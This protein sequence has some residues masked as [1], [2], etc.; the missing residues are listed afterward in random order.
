V[1]KYRHSKKTVIFIVIFN[2]LISFGGGY[3]IRFYITFYRPNIQ[4]SENPFII[5]VPQGANFDTILDSLD[6]QQ[7]LRNRKSFIRAAKEEG[8]P[9][10]IKGGRYE[11]STGMNNKKVVRRLVLGQQKPVNLVVSGNIRS[12]ERLSAVLTRNIEADSL[13]MLLLLTDEEHINRMGFDSTSLFSLIL[14]NT[15]EVY[16]NASPQNII[17]RLY[18]EYNRFWS[19]ERRAKASS[20][21]LSLDQVSTLASIVYEETRYQ[22][23]MATIAGVYMNRLKRGI[24]LQADPTLIFSLRDPTIRRVLSVDTKVDSPYN[25]YKHQGLPPGPICVPSLATIDAVLNYQTHNYLFFC[26]NSEFTGSHL[27]ATNYSDHLRNAKAYHKA[28]NERGI[29]R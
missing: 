12:I 23:E 11:L 7:C 9:E 14:P 16:W 22:P 13:S 5:Y 6:A 17:E 20:I 10:R 25:T 8:L 18:K 19:E 29:K 24:P 2:L 26:A 27:F 28:L 21:G 1:K 15:Y 3:A 4:T